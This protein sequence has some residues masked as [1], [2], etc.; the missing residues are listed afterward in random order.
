[1]KFHFKCCC[2]IQHLAKRKLVSIWH[3]VK[4]DK[5]C[6]GITRVATPGSLLFN[7][8][9]DGLFLAIKKEQVSVILEMTCLPVSTTQVYL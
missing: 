6:Q 7:I 1:M 5:L 9:I 8:N 3:S 4:W 2:A